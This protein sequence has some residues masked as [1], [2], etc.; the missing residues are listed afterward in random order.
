[1]NENEKPKL[2]LAVDDSPLALQT[3]KT[4]LADSPYKLICV[5]S[6]ADA[7]RFLAKN[8]PDLYIL[9]LEMPEM[10][11]QELAWQIIESKKAAPIIFLTGNR[12][13]DSVAKAISVGAADFIIKPMD[14][15]KILSRIEKFID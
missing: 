14:R 5:T 11:G 9:D 13:T 10:D 7:L 15:E 8:K 2:I 4:Y 3:L 1:M 6:G 12:D